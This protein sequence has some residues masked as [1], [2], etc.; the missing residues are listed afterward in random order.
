MLSGLFCRIVDSKN[1]EDSAEDEARLVNFQRLKTLSG[2][3]V[4]EVLVI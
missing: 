1:V 2:P 3:L 4:S